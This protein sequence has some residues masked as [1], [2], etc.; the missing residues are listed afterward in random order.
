MMARRAKGEGDNPILNE[1]TGKWICRLELPKGKDGKRRRK[2]FSGDTK[3]ESSQKREAFRD[4]KEQ[5]IREIDDKDSLEYLFS[6]WL[7][8][9]VHL[10]PKTVQ[11]YKYGIE[12]MPRWM[13]EKA[14]VSITTEDVE[15]MTG[16][17]VHRGD[18]VYIA[19][20]AWDPFRSAMQYA[21]QKL[22][23]IA[24]N[25]CDDATKPKPAKKI[26]T[27]L[28]AEQLLKLKKV[29]KGRIDDVFVFNSMVGMRLGEILALR[30]SDVDMEAMTVTV[31]FALEQVDSKP[32]RLVETKGRNIRTIRLSNFAFKALKRRLKKAKAEGLGPGDCEWVWPRVGSNWWSQSD[33]SQDIWFPIRSQIDCADNF[34]FHDLRHTAASIWF[35]AGVNIVT[36]SR[37]L[38]HGDVA[39]TARVYAHMI[40]GGGEAAAS[41]ADAF[42]VKASKKRKKKN[43]RRGG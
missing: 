1:R 24:V 8:N 42:M 10:K 31:R 5:K 20:Y 16:E 41:K 38:G 33:F 11:N 3:L 4:D 35:E 37:N 9:S 18:S 22:K 32:T 13:L 12:K 2:Q 43:K 28:S 25:P 27:P 14:V 6:I 39:T 34:T 15:N 17:I 23:K 30:W 19:R 40:G 21:K 36:V 26:V 7:R 29:C